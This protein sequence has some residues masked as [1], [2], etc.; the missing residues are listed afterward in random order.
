[1]RSLRH[2]V[3]LLMIP[4]LFLAVW[5]FLAVNLPAWSDEITH[6]AT[7]KGLLVSGQP[8][9]W[10]FDKGELSV[11]RYTMCLAISYPVKCVYQNLW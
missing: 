7:A 11:F 5:R 9:E 1:M 8:L 10:M 2:I 3:V 6:L 4:A